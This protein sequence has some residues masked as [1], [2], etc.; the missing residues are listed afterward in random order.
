MVWLLWILSAMAS[1]QSSDYTLKDL[2]ILEE[3]GNYPDFFLH[4]KDVRPAQRGSAWERMVR[5][6]AVAWVDFKLKRKMF[7]RNSFETIE[8]IALWPTLRQD[9]FFQIKR[10]EYALGVLEHCFASADDKSRPQCR[11]WLDQFWMRSNR[12]V[13][14]GHR[15]AKLLVEQEQPGAWALLAEILSKE[16]SKD[17]CA[18]S[19]V[20]NQL[21][22]KISSDK[23]SHPEK[24]LHPACWKAMVPGLREHLFKGN[25][26][27]GERLFDILS[28]KGALEQEEK[29]FY[30]VL[31]ILNGP[32]VG[33]T[34]N[35]AWN[36]MRELGQ[37][38]SRREKVLRRLTKMDP[39]PDG[40]VGMSHPG[41]RKTLL[42]FFSLHFPEYFNHYSKICLDYLEGRGSWP[43]G[44]PTVRCRDFFR[45]T[46][47]VVSDQLYLR[48][49]ALKKKGKVVD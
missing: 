9:E 41:K 39:L 7:A 48:Y 32:R 34:F 12:T 15:L 20:Q 25:G 29:D 2:E 13:M 5:H 24:S 6:M 30:F 43:Q 16:E 47:S 22:E 37:D 36:K 35:L 28:A 8:G 4:A 19:F 23:G 26:K 33:K 21:L 42:N 40:L 45:Y 49:S 11:Q 31:F 38:F 46:D 17:Y 10:G 14:V 44:N 18:D 27:G 1:G 3:Q